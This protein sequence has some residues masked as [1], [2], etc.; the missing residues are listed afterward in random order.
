MPD[1]LLRCSGAMGLFSRLKGKVRA[2]ADPRWECRP[3]PAA[4]AKLPAVNPSLL[5]LP[6]AASFPA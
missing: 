3:C 5:P 4:A 1:P 6:A 2:A